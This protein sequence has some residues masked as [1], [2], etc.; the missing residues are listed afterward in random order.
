MVAMLCTFLLAACDLNLDATQ[1][2]PFTEGDTVFSAVRWSD[3][4]GAIDVVFAPANGYGDLNNTANRQAFLDDIAD[5][6]DTGFWQNNAIVRNL[7]KFNFWYTTI[8]G[9]VQAPSNPNNCPIVTWPNVPDAAFAEV[10]VLLHT[11][12][13]RDCRW[14]N[15]VT[16]EPTSY[17][18]VVH[19]ASHAAFNL[20]DEYCCDGGYW[21]ISPVLYNT[22]N[23]CT[24][25]AANA[26]WRDCD[27]ITNGTTTV[28]WWRS[29]DSTIDIMSAGGSVVLEYGRG[30]WVVM[31]NVLQGLNSG[32]IYNP[33]VFAPSAWSW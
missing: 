12:D 25:D 24:N 5:M 1:P 33:E 31:R 9:T 4:D 16:S 10:L 15:R 32:T 18:T 3:P 27:Q 6:I 23:G 30:D 7:G 2:P 14:G 21:N 13:L 28:N 8:S 26:A 19:E 17:R 20:P 11:N 22:Q 29:E